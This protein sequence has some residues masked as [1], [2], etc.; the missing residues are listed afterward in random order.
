[1]DSDS[2][3]PGVYRHFKGGRYQVKGVVYHSE[4]EEEL[5]LYKPLY[6]DE[7]NSA[8]WVRPLSMFLQKVEVDGALV[9]RF[10]Y[11]EE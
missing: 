5:V 2:I 8:L 3:K 10:C 4:T 11:L 9:A 7:K 6:G 1:M